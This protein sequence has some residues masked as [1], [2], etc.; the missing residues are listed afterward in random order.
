MSGVDPLQR[1]FE[2][3]ESRRPATRAEVLGAFPALTPKEKPMPKHLT[4]EQLA[5]ELPGRTLRFVRELSQLSAKGNPTAIVLHDEE[6]GEMIVIGTTGSL[7]VSILPFPSD[8]T[9]T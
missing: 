4:Y 9:S 2:Q 6:R 7:D 1:Y 5:D 3:I 8:P